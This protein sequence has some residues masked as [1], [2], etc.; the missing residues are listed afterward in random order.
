MSKRRYLGAY[1][2]GGQILLINGGLIRRWKVI[3]YVFVLILCY[4]SIHFL[5]AD[6]LTTR[7]RNDKI[8][9]NLNAEY[10][11]KHA[12][13]LFISKRQEIDKRL[14]KMGS[15]LIAPDNPPKLT[16]F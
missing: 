16:K 6:T 3:L 15:D 4:I 1:I 14:K 8:I 13:L 10:T 2:F 11:G 12:R 5:V 7:V 9:T